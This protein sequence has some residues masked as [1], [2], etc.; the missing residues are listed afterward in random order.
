MGTLKGEVFQAQ[1]ELER[2]KSQHTQAESSLEE[3]RRLWEAEIKTRSHLG[4][5]A[6]VLMI[7]CVL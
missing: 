2:E 5:K 3:M 6:S 4:L 1:A 7:V